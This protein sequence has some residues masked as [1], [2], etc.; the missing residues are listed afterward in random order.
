MAGVSRR[1]TS[2][3]RGSLLGRDD[4]L[5]VIDATVDAATTQGTRSVLVVRG[6][7][8]VGKSALVGAV[9]DGLPD[10]VQVL[11]TAGVE[12]EADLGFAGLQRMLRPLEA[13]VGSLAPPQRA[14]LDAAFGL[15]DGAPPSRF[16]ISLA[17]LNLLAAAAIEAPIVAVIDDAH[18]LDPET[19]DVLS[20]VARRLL[21]DRV[22][23]LFLTRDGPVSPALLDD[24]PVLEVG[25][26]ADDAAMELLRPHASP[27]GHDD[28]VDR[29]I[30]ETGGNPLA[31]LELA[32]SIDS[33]DVREREHQPS[34]LTVGLRITEHFGAQLAQLPEATRLLL[35]A[36]AADPHL[37]RHQID[38][39]AGALGLVSEDLDP[40][41]QEGLV[42]LTPANVVF[43]HPLV[44]SAAYDIGSP[45]DRRR[46]HGAIAATLDST[47]D[48][49]RRAWHRADSVTGPD[50][51]VAADLAEAAGRAATRGAYRS[52][53]ELLARSAHATP[54]N[55]RR[56]WRHLAA[57]A[58]SF[59]V[60]DQ[61][62]ASEQTALAKASADDAFVQAQV[63]RSEASLPAAGH[64]YASGAAQ[65]AAVAVELDR[66]DRVTARQ[67]AL[68]AACILSIA[69]DLAEGLDPKRLAAII[70]GLPDDP[71]QP[72]TVF[73]DLVD[74]FA[75][76][77][78]DGWMVG[79]PLLRRAIATWPSQ[80]ADPL[81]VLANSTLAYWAATELFD[82]DGLR[83]LVEHNLGVSRAAHAVP[84]E[85][86]THV[87]RVRLLVFEG[88]L[89]EA[90]LAIAEW[91]DVDELLGR[92][93]NNLPML[94]VELLALRGDPTAAGPALEA[95]RVL[96]RIHGQG[97][98]LMMAATAEALMANAAGDYQAAARLVRPVVDDDTTGYRALALTELVEAAVRTGEEQVALD[99]AA[100][101]AERAEAADND[102]ARGLAARCAALVAGHDDAEERYQAA[103][104]YFESTSTVRELARTHL[105]Y[106]EW[107]RRRK[108]RTDARRELRTAFELYSEMGAAGFAER[109]RVEL[110][111][112]G[113]HARKR[114]PETAADLTPR[115]QQIVALVEAG[116]T[117]AE[118][119]ERLYISANTVDYHLRKVFRKLGISSRRQLIR[120]A[121][122]P[123]SE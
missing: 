112:T 46:V 71:G 111:A 68:D 109:A 70:R 19:L 22:A 115:E 78:L 93:E 35:L 36:A 13:E 87:F 97:S 33:G 18:W 51:E 103:I 59:V 122:I 39:V 38:R 14:A 50:P 85:W 89:R 62:R 101:V 120:A 31:L 84:V 118:I 117:N 98:C 121:T 15:V 52:R 100:L 96:G 75:A 65:M 77:I 61:E 95:L 116:A 110:M 11:R 83:A 32:G 63:A 86:A 92:D 60:G 27:P 44:C 94:Q 20:F 74:G 67:A 42:E 64:Q 104:G 1:A 69:G 6:E 55:R 7:P 88:R 8:G 90:E 10:T 45:P 106:G 76:V 28:L 80:V 81:L 17:A 66:F 48:L 108:R 47:F 58:A 40:A 99:A 37:E 57:A 119:G 25:G 91:R 43:R 24:L 73:A 123:A 26:L 16:H 29:L 102:V 79:A 105:V 56:A 53:I 12:A 21:A 2:V 82:H 114:S 23:L 5:A 107:L 30:Q 49:E 9:V 34:P 113:E 72:P 41:V 54:D 4:E 3:G